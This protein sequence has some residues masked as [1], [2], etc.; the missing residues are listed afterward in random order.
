MK[1]KK[2]I[3]LFIAL[4]NVFYFN[5]LAQNNSSTKANDALKNESATTIQSGY[6][7]YKKM[8]FSIWDYAELGY[9]ENKSSALL[10]NTLKDN[11]FTVEAGVAG[12]PTAFVATYGSGSPVIAILAEYDA[13]PGISQDNSPTKTAIPNKSSAHACGHHLFGVGSVAAG[14][15]IKKLLETGK[16]KGTIKVF[17]CPAEEGGSG[18]VYMVREGLFKNVD[19]ALHWHPSDN[20]SV[21]YTSALANKS[22]KFRF[23][24]IASHASAS[25]D[26]GRSALDAVE[27]LNNMVN[28]MR[29]HIPQETRIHYVITN[30]G[31]APNVVPEF[32]EVYYYV[33]HPEKTVAVSIFDRI[34][35]AA[36]GAALGTETKMD[37]EIIGGT[38]DLLINKTLA[39]NMQT[40][41][42]KV[43]GIRY[44]AEEIVFAKKL[45]TSFLGKS[46]LI[47]S[48]AIVK[49]I[50]IEKNQGS[51]DVGDVSY[52]V[53]TVGVETATWVPGTSAHS[54]Q[55]VACGGTDI[56]IKGMMVAA[57]TLAFT[58]L[59]LFTNPAL[60]KKAKEEF[61]Q[62]KGDY[63]YKA[64]LGDRKPALNY[65]D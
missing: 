16:I 60:I 11:G 49:A 17:G 2:T 34:T 7:A 25:P 18:K 1:N 28:M 63:Q 22:A 45:Q 65:R 54:W 47:D 6:E 50:H 42:E 3:L 9:K 26:Q 37:Y 52:A 55:A 12:M 35:K 51:T 38:H 27:A 48:A 19:I 57:K 41:L 13:L 59:D 30:G 64:L 20:N 46:E 58:A 5:C 56:G 62:T 53:P 29:E 61:I 10:Q 15:A 4:I 39:L 32:A 33:R 21:T 23:Y 24:G 31:K 36:E 43:G 44:T 8:A 14:I 40:N